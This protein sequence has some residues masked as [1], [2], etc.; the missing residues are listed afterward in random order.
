MDEAM[1][2]GL[3]FRVMGWSQGFGMEVG[4]G[5]LEDSEFR[6]VGIRRTPHPAI[7]V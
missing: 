7:V 3:G 2:Q 5:G 6:K 1:G 4:G